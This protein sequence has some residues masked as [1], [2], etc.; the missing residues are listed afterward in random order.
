[1]PIEIVIEPISLEDLR[2]MAREQFGDFVKAVV[3]VGRSLMAV[4]GEL[5][6]DE[7]AALLEHGACQADLWGINIYPDQAGPDRI[8]FDSMINVRPAHGNRTR[9]VDDPAVRQLIADTVDRLSVLEQHVVW[10]ARDSGGLM[11]ASPGH[12][13]LAAGGW[14]RLSL[15]E[16]LG[17]VGSEVGRLRRWR[18]RDEG[19]AERAFHRALE[20]LDLTLADP[21]WRGRLKEIAR[22]R[23]LLC[24]AALGGGQY[25]TTLEDMDRYFLQFAVAARRCR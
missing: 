2:R 20:L 13:G 24:D 9:A 17:N 1:M 12:A 15:A 6:A 18:G 21:R 19:L 3:D 25:D 8:E 11:Q 23:E 14:S 5:H 7:E 4:G 16:Q 10:S 22:A